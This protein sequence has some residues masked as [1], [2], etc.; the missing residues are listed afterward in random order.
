MKW[1]SFDVRQKILA[2]FFFFKKYGETSSIAGQR[3]LKVN[4]Y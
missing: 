4:Q 2:K 3:G 1:P